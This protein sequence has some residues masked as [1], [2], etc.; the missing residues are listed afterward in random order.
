MLNEI[1]M[2]WPNWVIGATCTIGMLVPSAAERDPRRAFTRPSPNQ[3]LFPLINFADKNK[4]APDTMIRTLKTKLPVLAGHIQETLWLWNDRVWK[5]R[6]SA[7]SYSHNNV[8]YFFSDSSIAS[9]VISPTQEVVQYGGSKAGA[10]GSN[11]HPK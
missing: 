3:F 11:G 8:R 1:C 4:F 10:R 9:V 5:G 7:P 6:A 2:R